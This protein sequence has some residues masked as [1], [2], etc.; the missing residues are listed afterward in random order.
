VPHKNAC[1]LKIL[2]GE[3]MKKIFSWHHKN[4]SEFDLKR[5]YDQKWYISGVYR[6]RSVDHQIGVI[7][8]GKYG[9]ELVEGRFCFQTLANALFGFGLGTCRWGIVVNLGE[10]EQ[11]G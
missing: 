10:V 5:I 8:R 4:I 2:L 7:S 6:C 9:A 11:S 1:V 3:Y